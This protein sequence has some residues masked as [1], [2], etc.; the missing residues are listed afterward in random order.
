MPIFS[1]TSDSDLNGNPTSHKYDLIGAVILLQKVRVKENFGG[2]CIFTH[3]K[4]SS[5]IPLL[6]GNL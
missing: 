5:I 3:C 4:V 6:G 2:R 1:K